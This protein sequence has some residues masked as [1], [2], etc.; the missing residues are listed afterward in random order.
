M[1]RLSRTFVF[2]RLPLT[3]LLGLALLS[4][5]CFFSVKAQ[6][7]AQESVTS[8][9]MEEGTPSGES[10]SPA[11]ENVPEATVVEVSDAS[12]GLNPEGQMVSLFFTEWQHAAIREARNSRGLV[13]PLSQ[14]ERDDIA[15]QGPTAEPIAL[16]KPPPEM[17]YVSLGGILYTGE[18]DW[19][20]WL[21]GRR[22]TPD[23]LPREVLDLKVFKGYIDVKWLDD[24]S[25]QIYPIRLRPHQRFNLDTRIFL[26]G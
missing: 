24:Y 22:V 25:N 2:L 19:I 4:F 5:A 17:R 16:P 13:R 9:S 26:P 18:G 11:D 3:V 1:R 10:V 23:S 20:I 21:N 12:Q 15:G 6:E 14:E 7:P 8:Q